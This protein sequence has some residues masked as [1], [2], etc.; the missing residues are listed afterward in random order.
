M[1]IQ[2]VALVT[3]AGAGIGLAIAA[4]LATRFKVI[5]T[6]L[7]E[8]A[9]RSA[10]D[11]IRS[12]GGQAEG[13]QLDVCS[14]TDIDAVIQQCERVDVLVN[15][16]GIQYVSRL[17][18]FP[19]GRW[20]MVLNVLLV[21]PAMLTR[22]AMPR[23]K[24]QN[25]GRIVNIGSIHS[26][27][28]SPYKSAYVAAKHGLLGFSK[29]VALEVAEHDITINTICPAYVKTALVAQQIAA[30]A[31]EHQ[32]SEQAVIDNIMLAPMPKKQ[33]IGMDEITASVD[34]LISPA[35]KNITGQTIVLDGG[36]TA[37]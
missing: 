15:N 30:Q 28:A 35:G 11:V 5:V 6:D 25:Y 13:I 19:V 23:M 2:P 34:F 37:R 9:A 12:N 21:G 29:A 27:V 36:W 33:F 18:D 26:L 31:H 14:S 3:G 22:A 10:A 7:D 20:Q 8:Y 1:A 4:S 16:A 24:Q 32:I 17:E